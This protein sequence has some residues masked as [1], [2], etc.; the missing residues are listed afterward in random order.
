MNKTILQVPVSK[1]I[2]DQAA[3]V[4]TKMGFSSLQEAVRLFLNQLVDEKT[5]LKFVEK[6]LRVS[7]RAA[8]RLDKMVEDYEKGKLKTKKFSDVKSLMAD[9]LS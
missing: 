4:A 6:P 1:T 5:D 3:A 2:R 9:L 7:P 8:K